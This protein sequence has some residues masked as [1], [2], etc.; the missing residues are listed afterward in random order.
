[1][2]GAPNYPTYR[3]EVVDRTFNR[4]PGDW[5]LQKPEQLFESKEPWPDLRLNG[6]FDVVDL[7]TG[8]S[9]EGQI[10]DAE[11]PPEPPGTSRSE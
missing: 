6:W 3:L 1:M 7:K 9:G 4:Q 10:E 11:I 2:S 8:R 5:R